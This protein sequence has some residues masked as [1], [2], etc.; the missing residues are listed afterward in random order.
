MPRPKTGQGKPRGMRIKDDIWEPAL[1]RARAERG[2]R[3]PM[4]DVVKNYLRRYGAH[5]PADADEF[6]SWVLV[7]LVV[8]LLAERGVRARF[9]PDTDLRAAADTAADLLRVLGVKAAPPADR[10]DDA[11]SPPP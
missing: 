3:Y 7:E 9:G 4:S 10:D 6:D 8:Q 5:L 1:E 11:S 2:K